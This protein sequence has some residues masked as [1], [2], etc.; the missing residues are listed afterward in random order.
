MRSRSPRSPRTSAKAF[1]D[2]ESVVTAAVTQASV[3]D[4]ELYSLS[5]TVDLAQGAIPFTG[6]ILGQPPSF[7]QTVGENSFP[8]TP[9]GLGGSALAELFIRD[10]LVGIVAGL[11]GVVA[12]SRWRPR[13]GNLCA[14]WLLASPFPMFYLWR[15]DL[16]LIIQSASKLLLI[17]GLCSIGLSRRADQQARHATPLTG[18]PQLAAR[19]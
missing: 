7:A 19:Q 3:G 17:L 1:L 2:F 12:L 10:G 14:V 13:S 15:S 18:V 6:T 5:S 16:S 9:W 8:D 4:R 11:T